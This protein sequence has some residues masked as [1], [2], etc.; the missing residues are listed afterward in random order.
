MGKN[1]KAMAAVWTAILTAAVFLAGCGMTGGESETPV[2]T[3][4][5]AEEETLE[6]TEALLENAGLTGSI[7]DCTEEGA[8]VVETQ[9][10]GDVA[11]APALGY[12][13][14]A[15]AVRYQ[16]GMEIERISLQT[17]GTLLE[18][19][20]IS[21]SDIEPGDQ[22]YAYGNWTENG[23]FLAD[24]MIIVT[25][26]VFTIVLT[27]RLLLKITFIVFGFLIVH[28]FLNRIHLR[29]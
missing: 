2:E 9:I 26:I 4:Q 23:E 15:A 8:H 3:Q 21:V 1:G 24:R 5:T 7:A 11:V 19:K 29:I 20:Q 18:R 22:V 27:I 10:E 6:D 12:E 28:K 17:D 13:T 25:I 16:D 14:E